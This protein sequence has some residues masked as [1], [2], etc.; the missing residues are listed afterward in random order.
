MKPLL[1]W[2]GGKAREISEIY[3]MIPDFDRYIEPFFGGGALYF[4]LMPERAAINDTAGDLMEFYH[5]IRMGDEEFKRCLSCYA[6]SFQSLLDYGRLHVTELLD[7]WSLLPNE[8]DAADSLSLLM[9]VWAPEI[10]AMFSHPIV[11]DME[12]FRKDNGNLFG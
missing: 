1:K 7:V 2:P 5:L 10:D 4:H 9:E 3:G 11:L 12:K 8:E 6:D